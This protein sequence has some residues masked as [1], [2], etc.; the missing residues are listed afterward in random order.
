MPKMID[1]EDRCRRVTA[2]TLLEMCVELN[3][4][5]LR[6]YKLVSMGYAWVDHCWWAVMEYCP[7]RHMTT[8]A[9]PEKYHAAAETGAELD[10]DKIIAERDA[11]RAWVRDAV[12][13]ASMLRDALRDLYYAWDDNASP[14]QI[15]A[16]F[17]KAYKLL[18]HA[19]LAVTN[20]IRHA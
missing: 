19:E 11:L 7:H 2:D 5:T 17:D 20:D 3:L 12:T 9:A 15:Q 10:V 1:V 16:A 18:V 4:L 6:G 8:D 14:E 13:E